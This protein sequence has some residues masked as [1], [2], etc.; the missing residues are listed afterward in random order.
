MAILMLLTFSSIS[1]AQKKDKKGKDKQEAG[2]KTKLDSVSYII[3]ADIGNNLQKSEIEINP[4]M[5]M[6]GVTDAYQ[7]KDTI[8]SE[9][10]KQE[11][12]MGL[13]MEMQTKKQ[14]KMEQASSENRKKGAEFLAQNKSKAGVV[15][16]PSGL[17]YKIIK[18]GEGQFPKET[19]TVEV[20]Y[21]GK[22]TDGTIFDSSYKRGQPISFPLNG[23]IRGWTEGVQLMK[24]GAAFEFYIPA[25][26]AYGDRDLGS[27]PA[28][29]TLI[30]KVELL[31]VK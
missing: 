30:F 14:K 9:S 3:G 19:D 17:Q 18:Q 22:L 28:G 2:F 27:I 1:F 25:D 10:V 13:Q 20:N 24:P 15:E 26:L 7:H 29:S 5:F 21:E 6:K 31:S 16:L 12:I 11:I 4:E 23:V 8:F